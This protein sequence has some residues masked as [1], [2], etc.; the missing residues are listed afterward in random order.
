MPDHYAATVHTPRS[1][2]ARRL[3][4]ERTIRGLTQEHVAAHVLVSPQLYGHWENRRRVPDCDDARRLDGFYGLDEV[5]AWMHP[6]IVEEA[7]LPCDYV[8][9]ADEEPRACLIRTY[10]PLRIP[11]MAQDSEHTRGLLR[12]VNGPSLFVLVTQHAVRTATMAELAHVLG[13]IARPNSCVQVVPNGAHACGA[14]TLLGFPEG[15]DLAH[16]EEPDGDG[17][18]IEIPDRVK[19][20][21]VLWE[22]IRSTAFPAHV[23]TAIIRRAIASKQHTSGALPHP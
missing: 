10:H 22:D 17:R 12:R 1:L 7:A 14:F 2:F 19:R 21:A 6:L 23:S 13:L 4:K 9:F 15:G 8:R 11:P 3:V 16:F 5:F 18:V 20:L